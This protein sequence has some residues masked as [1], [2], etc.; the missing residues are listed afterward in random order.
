MDRIEEKIIRQIDKNR[1]GIIRFARDIYAHAELGYKETR[2]AAKFE[3]W[4]R[5]L[6]LPRVS[7]GLAVT[8]V[9]AYLKAGGEGP[10]LALIGEL[11]A[12]RIPTHPYANPETQAAHCCGH[13]VQLAGVAG[14]AIALA[15]AEVAAALDGNVVFFAV[16][17]EEY[18]EISFKNRLRDAG[19]IRYGGGKCELIRIG[20]F[21]DISLSLAHHSSNDGLAV[22]NGSS[23][24]FVSKIVRILGRAA[25]AAAGPHL[26]INALNAAALGHTAMQFHRETYRDEDSV[27]IHS[28]ITKGGDQVNVIPDEVVLEVQVRGKSI[29]AILD[30]NRKTNRSYMAGAYALGAGC[31]IETLPGY[32]PMIPTPAHPA[33]AEAA[34]LASGSVS[35]TLTDPHRHGSASSDVG[36]L[37]HIQP[38]LCFN[39]GGTRGA[40]HS[41]LFEIVDEEAA[42]VTT[43]KIFALGAYRLLRHKAAAAREI[44]GSYKPFF[45]RDSYVAFMESLIKKER[46]D[47]E[48]PERGCPG[49]TATG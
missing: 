18:G 33:L 3:E 36:D 11:D 39:T 47:I 12:L 23:N 7:T 26:G 5:V 32:M 14:A 38:V 48:I 21:D 1:E 42:Y 37:Q 27:R 9:K 10:C 2:S 24:G 31:E 20:A 19:A 15:D 44:A 49:D 43:A 28:I 17:A 30:A 45:T 16:P 46:R 22:G 8:G 35:V 34:R 29:E 4:L 41:P 25:H 40:Y 6:N 13:H